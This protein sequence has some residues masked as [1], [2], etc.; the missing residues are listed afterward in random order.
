[1][2]NTNQRI[3]NAMECGPGDGQNAVAARIYE[4]MCLDALQVWRVVDAMATG[5]CGTQVITIFY[6][7]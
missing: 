2:I 1:M 7:W 4:A 6:G 5:E 3:L